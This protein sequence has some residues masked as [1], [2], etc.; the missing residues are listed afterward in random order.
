M[1]EAKSL[2]SRNSSF[3]PDIYGLQLAWDS[4]SLGTFKECPRKYQYSIIEGW[5]PRQQSV[6]LW[7][8]QLYHK[9]LEGYDHARSAGESHELAQQYALYICLVQTW[10]FAKG[11]VIS[12]DDPNKTRETLCRSVLWYLEQFGEN[13]SCQTVQLANGK[14]AVEL[15]FRV[16]L[17]HI[18]PTGDPYILCGHLDRLVIFSDQYYVLDRKTSK[19]QIDDRFFQSFSPSNQMQIYNLGGQLVYQVPTKGIIID[20]AQVAVTFTRFKRGFVNYSASQNEEFYKELGVWFATAAAYAEAGFWPKNE[21]SCNNFGGC[22]FLSI[23]SKPPS[24][25]ED[26]LKAAFFQRIWN[27]LQVRGDI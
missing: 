24:I 8:G 7:F 25:R 11:R 22:P 3:S 15:S 26:W 14:P 23:C 18:S 20:G 17:G 16:T 19:H 21:K 6:H 4:T 12:F 27:P 1:T 5:Q 13:D 10:D 9:A 2:S